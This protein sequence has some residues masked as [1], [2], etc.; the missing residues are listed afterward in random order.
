MFLDFK[1]Y[2][3]FEKNILIVLKENFLLNI[4]QYFKL[5]FFIS[6]VFFYI[7]VKMGSGETMLS[8]WDSDECKGKLFSGDSDLV[9]P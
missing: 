6:S 5:P 1:K 2:K 3:L 7:S 4:K 9:N 8:L